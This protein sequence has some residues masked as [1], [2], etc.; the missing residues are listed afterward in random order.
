MSPSQSQ[1]CLKALI[2]IILIPTHFGFASTY[3]DEERCNQGFSRAC[4]QLA[5]KYEDGEGIQKDFQKAFQ[6]YQK[7]AEQGLALAQYNLALKFYKGQG[8]GQSFEK[9]ADWFM[10]AAKNGVADAQHN[11]GVMY[12][13][14]TGVKK[15]IV[16]AH[17]WFDVL[18]GNGDIA[19]VKVRDLIAKGMTTS[20]LSLARQLAQNWATHQ[21]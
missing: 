10:K 18:A 9:A 17:M 2:L 13:K 21:N 14:G 12:V 7:A 1:I 19:A 3:S 11:L 6:F 16:K 15:D 20:Q 8:I 4:F 5:V